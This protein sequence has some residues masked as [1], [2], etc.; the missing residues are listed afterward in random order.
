MDDRLKHDRVEV[1]LESIAQ[2]LSRLVELVELSTAKVNHEYQGE[3][4]AFRTMP[5][6]S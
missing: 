4:R 5:D 3:R 2:S 6:A 1:A